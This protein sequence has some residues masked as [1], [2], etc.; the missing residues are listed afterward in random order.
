[1]STVTHRVRLPTLVKEELRALPRQTFGLA[2]LAVVLSLFVPVGALL[3]GGEAGPSEVLIFM[4][5]IAELVVAIIVASRVAAARRSRFVDSLYTTPLEQRTWFASQAILG[6]V[7]ALLVLAIQVPFL[8]VHFAWIGVPA[9]LPALLVAALGMGAFAVALGLF[10][11]VVVGEAGSGAAGALAGGIGFMSFILFIIHG[12]VLTGP[13]SA[14][15]PMLLRLTALSPLSL[16]T[17]GVGVHLFEQAAQSWWRPMV[18][19]A[20]LVA[21]LAGAA[22]IAYTRAQGPLGWDGR[23]GRLIVA[24]LVAA[25]VLTPIASAEVTF[26][27]QDGD[28]GPP[29]SPGESTQVAFVLRDAPLNDETFTLSQIYSAPDLPL[30]EPVELDALVLIRAPEEAQVHGVRIEIV[31]VDAVRIE[32]GGTVTVPDGAPHARGRPGSGWESTVDGPLRPVYRVPVTLR[33]TSVE[34]L[35]NSPALVEVR[36]VYIADG[37]TVDSDARMALDAEVP[38]A[39]AQLALAS[40]PLPLAV[41]GALVTRK[42]R[43]R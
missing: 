24:A 6:A 23:R 14:S 30:D 12:V 13:P 15:Q 38:S 32:S 17:D 35:G 2:V 25:A 18:G 1:M 10:C 37:R 28:D 27:A 19:F 9:D 16:V 20:A 5:L 40:A 4:W 11:G 39:K 22:W 36:T 8:L 41:I 21:G 26:V 3:Y 7:L 42:I 31:A 29:Y 34:S 43:T 33:A